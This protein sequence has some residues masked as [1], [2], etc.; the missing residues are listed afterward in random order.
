MSTTNEN[1]NQS[2]QREKRGIKI[3]RTLW[4][5]S[6][7]YHIYYKRS[8]RYSFIGKNLIR[9]L[10][11]IG[12]LAVGAWF[13]T[14]YLIDLN[15]VMGYITD[16]FPNWIV[17]TTLYLS[18]SVL[19]LAPPDLYILWAKTLA[20]P[21]TMVL[22]LSLASYF[23]GITSYFVGQQLYRLPQIQAW[24]NVKFDEQFKIFKKFSGLLIVISALAPL[25]FSW[26]SVVSGVVRYPFSKFALIATTRIARFFI[27]AYIFFKVIS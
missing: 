23:G 13:V 1:S 17:V 7:L 6:Y 21:Y 11:V 3:E 12:V 14:K 19:G 16:N 26:V 15:Q 25:P 10:I 5:R 22:W 24:V 18:E 20:D 9:V 4:Q 2:P 27:Y 8:G